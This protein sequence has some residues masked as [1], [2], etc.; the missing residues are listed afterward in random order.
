MKDVDYQAL[1]TELSEII[2]QLQD[3]VAIDKAI[4]LYERG[5]KITEQLEKYLDS[6]ENKI[7]K[8]TEK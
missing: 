4:E 1:S 5:Q 2:T 7:V 3:D 6:V 8:V